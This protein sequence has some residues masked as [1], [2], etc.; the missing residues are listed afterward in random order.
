VIVCKDITA[1][2]AIVGGVA[3]G[4]RPYPAKPTQPGLTGLV[5]SGAG[6]AENVCAAYDA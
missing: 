6:D 2:F 5:V 3:D 4:A 1:L